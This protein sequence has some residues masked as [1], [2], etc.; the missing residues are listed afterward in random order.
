M[1]VLFVLGCFLAGPREF[2]AHDVS[3]VIPPGGDCTAMM[4]T[5]TRLASP[6]DFG[7][8]LRYPEQALGVSCG[9]ADGASVFGAGRVVAIS[10]V[11]LDQRVVREVQLEQPSVRVR[12][13]DSEFETSLA[14]SSWRGVRGQGEML[15]APGD[16]Y[17]VWRKDP[18]GLLYA[19][20]FCW[21]T[22]CTAPESWV[23]GV[24]FLP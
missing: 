21:R 7:L 2:T 14:G 13:L 23:E 24:K 5:G 18:S 16:Y 9:G 3:V 17:L 6:S 1:V 4:D 22:T 12:R 10:P 19:Y 11:G 8:W 15:G 20:V